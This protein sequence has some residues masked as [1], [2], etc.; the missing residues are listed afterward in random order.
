MAGVVDPELASE[1]LRDIAAVLGPEIRKRWE[2]AADADPRWLVAEVRDLA[3][4]NVRLRL[5]LR[6]AL[7]ARGLA[8]DD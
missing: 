3:A 5:F 4:R 7:E 1:M 6:R 8:S 2:A